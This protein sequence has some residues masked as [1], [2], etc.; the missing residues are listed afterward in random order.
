MNFGVLKRNKRNVKAA[1][2]RVLSFAL[3]VLLVL[4]MVTIAA[5]VRAKAA[6][7]NLIKNPNFESEDLS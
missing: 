2:R 3:A 5:P 7:Q 6:E 4:S 1:G